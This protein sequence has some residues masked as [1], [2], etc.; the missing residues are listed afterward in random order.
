MKVSKV[1]SIFGIW[2]GGNPP[3]MDAISP[4]VLVS[5]S[6]KN[7]IPKTTKIATK[8]AGI[9]LLSFGKPQMMK[10]VKATNPENKYNAFPVNQF[11]SP[12]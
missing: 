11:P 1:Q 9:I 6:K 7:T 12:S 3:L 2:N 10:M 8:E 4:T 5:K